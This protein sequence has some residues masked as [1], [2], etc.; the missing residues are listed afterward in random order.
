MSDI[1]SILLKVINALETRKNE[2]EEVKKQNEKNP[3]ETVKFVTQIISETAGIDESTLFDKIFEV[4][5]DGS[6]DGVWEKFLELHPS[7]NKRKAAEKKIKSLKQKA[8]KK[9]QQEEKKKQQPKKKNALE[10]EEILDPSV[11]FTIT[12][13]HLHS[14]E[15]L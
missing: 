7:K 9:K 1:K 15:I 10:D 5:A 4:C 6:L 8:L 14:I 2:I 12:Y 11:T 3:E 13:S